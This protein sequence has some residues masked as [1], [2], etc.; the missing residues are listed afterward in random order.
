MI[1]GQSFINNSKGFRPY[2][3]FL[4]LHDAYH[5]RHPAIFWSSFHRRVDRQKSESRAESCTWRAH[6]ENHMTSAEARAFEG[7]DYSPLSLPRSL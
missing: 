5:W 4:Y 3:V 6:I 7:T 2:D 1:A